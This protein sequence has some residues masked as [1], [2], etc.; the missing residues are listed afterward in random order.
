[1]CRSIDL[2]ETQALKNGEKNGTLSTLLKQF[3]V[4]LGSLSPQ[5]KNNIENSSIKKLD[6]LTLSIFDITSEDDINIILND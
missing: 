1:M 6:Q 2:F 5:T 3:Q 4:K